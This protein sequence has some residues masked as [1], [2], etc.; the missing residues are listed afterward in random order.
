MKHL[1]LVVSL[2]F[3]FS[4]ILFLDGVTWPSMPNPGLNPS[5]IWAW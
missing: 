3:V 5:A 4:G 2:A 1:A